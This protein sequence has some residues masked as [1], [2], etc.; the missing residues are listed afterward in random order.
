[1]LI[2]LWR[3]TQS[4]PVFERSGSAHRQGRGGA[5]KSIITMSNSPV[6]S[7]SCHYFE[8]VGRRCCQSAARKYAASQNAML[9]PVCSVV[10][11][12]C[13]PR[14]GIPAW[15]SG[16]VRLQ[17][18]VTAAGQPSGYP[19]QHARPSRQNRRSSIAIRYLQ[20]MKPLSRLM[21]RQQFA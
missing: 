14:S 3:L 20:S 12:P 15:T 4:A 6:I 8:R 13:F 17:I 1:M 18:N 2:S 16:I 10:Q 5:A 7:I 21:N 11:S 9:T 19:S